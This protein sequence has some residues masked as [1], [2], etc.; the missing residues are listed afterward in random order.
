MIRARQPATAP[1]MPDTALSKNT[2]A[3]ARWMPWAAALVSI[4]QI[5]A[6]L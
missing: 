6:A 2:G 4:E 5:V 1:I 3:T